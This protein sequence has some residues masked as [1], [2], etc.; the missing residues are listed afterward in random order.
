MKLYYIHQTSVLKI[1]NT[2]LARSAEECT[3]EELL[4]RTVLVQEA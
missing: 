3:I 4:G 2:N 1:R